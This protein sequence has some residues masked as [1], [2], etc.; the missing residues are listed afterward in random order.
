[1]ARSCPLLGQRPAIEARAEDGPSQKTASRPGAMEYVASTL[2]PGQTRQNV[3][4]R[5]YGLSRQEAKGS[6]DVITDPD[7]SDCIDPDIEL[8]GVNGELSCRTRFPSDHAMKSV[9]GRFSDVSRTAK[10]GSRGFEH[11]TFLG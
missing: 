3:Q 8:T 5:V 7:E 1:M 11:Y 6:P 10:M 9:H 2:P 4:P